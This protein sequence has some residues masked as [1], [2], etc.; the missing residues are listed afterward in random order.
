MIFKISKGLLLSLII[1]SGS[2][3][4][5]SIKDLKQKCANKDGKS[6]HIL[7]AYYYDK[8][9]YG[10]STKYALKSCSLD[11]AIACGVAGRAYE[12]GEGVKKD[13]KKAKLYYKK[14]CNLGLSKGCENAKKLEG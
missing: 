1:A 13:T 8:K 14:A 5:T 4:A 11:E 7:A 6:C 2:L 10:K 3:Y 12:N 9:D